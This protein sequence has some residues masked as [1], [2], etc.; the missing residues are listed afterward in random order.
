MD[1]TVHRQERELGTLLSFYQLH[2][3]CSKAVG[4]STCNADSKLPLPAC[5]SFQ[6]FKGAM[7]WSTPALS[8][9]LTL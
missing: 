9:S 7:A 8:S 5:S 1:S 6:P 2:P 4:I 3:M